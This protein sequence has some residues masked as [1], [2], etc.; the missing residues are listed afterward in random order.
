MK[1]IIG[2]TTDG[3][4]LVVLVPDISIYSFIK[5]DQ[6]TFLDLFYYFGQNLVTNRRRGGNEDMK[7]IMQDLNKRVEQMR[8][9][10]GEMQKLERKVLNQNM[11]RNINPY[12]FEH[13]WMASMEAYLNTVHSIYDL[14]KV[15]DDR[16][17]GT[18]CT[19][20]IENEDW[21]KIEMDIRNL[22]HH[23]ET[24]LLT[25]RNGTIHLFF[26]RLDSLRT[27]KYFQQERINGQNK[28][29]VEVTSHD[30][31]DGLLTA[32]NLYAKEYLEQIDQNETINA[33]TGFHQDGRLK[34]KEIRLSDLMSTAKTA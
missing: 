29:V 21:F 3:Q 17:T 11:R 33:I 14:L 25:T 10:V 18:L 28:I 15:I 26:E 20:Y 23:N 34:Q 5:K 24:P 7:Y 22:C 13:R 8:Y 27:V 1:K 19:R 9:Q 16:I 32:L 2:T 30:M 6:F 12:R 4:R 31:G